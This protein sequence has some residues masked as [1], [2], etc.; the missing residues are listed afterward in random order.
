MLTKTDK[1]IICVLFLA[2]T[3]ILGLVYICNQA[4]ANEAMIRGFA[5]WQAV[6]S[7]PSGSTNNK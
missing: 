6:I 3:L 1:L 7:E 4:L 5:W 2:V